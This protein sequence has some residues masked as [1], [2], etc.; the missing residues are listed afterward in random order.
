MLV[1][2]GPLAL[3]ISL[4]ALFLASNAMKKI[5]LQTKAFSQRFLAEQKAGFDTLD[6][7][8]VKLEKRL[9][10]AEKK[11][12]DPNEKDKDANKDAEPPK[13]KTAAN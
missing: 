3:F 12:K 4:V 13:L 2:V 5:D 11:L 1:I 10:E 8:L 7:K 9:R 6:N